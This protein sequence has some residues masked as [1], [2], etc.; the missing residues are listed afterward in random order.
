MSESI[1]DSGSPT[2][3]HGADLE[4][5]ASSEYTEVSYDELVNGIF[6]HCQTMT[7]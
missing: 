6:N 3:C 4:G 7:A 5:I 2:L 1:S